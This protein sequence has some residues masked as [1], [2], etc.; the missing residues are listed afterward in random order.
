MDER[1]RTVMERSRVGFSRTAVAD[2]LMATRSPEGSPLMMHAGLTPSMSESNMSVI[3]EHTETP[4]LTPRE[5]TT[6]ALRPGLSSLNRHEIRS[7]SAVRQRLRHSPSLTPFM[8]FVREES[9]AYDPM[10]RRDSDVSEAPLYKKEVLDDQMLVLPST[11]EPVRSTTSR[12]RAFRVSAFS[13]TVSLA[14]QQFVQPTA[15]GRRDPLPTTKQFEPVLRKASNVMADGLV[16]NAPGISRTDKVFDETQDEG[17]KTV[18]LRTDISYSPAFI[19]AVVRLQAWWRG[20]LTRT[21]VTASLITRRLRYGGPLSL[22]SPA[23]NKAESLLCPSSRRRRKTQLEAKDDSIRSSRLS[24]WSPELLEQL[25]AFLRILDSRP[26]SGTTI[27][28]FN[29]CRSN[30]CRAGN[31]NHVLK[32]ENNRYKPA[33]CSICLVRAENDGLPNCYSALV[34]DTYVPL[35]AKAPPFSFSIEKRAI[36]QLRASQEERLHLA[37]RSYWD[38]EKSRT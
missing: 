21:L 31:G 9:T 36:R 33:T 2:A 37:H 28:E 38:E 32:R 27:T 15:S 20:Q 30:R 29:T 24:P 8:T 22:E 14:S 16:I 6:Q 26:L 7:L 34:E 18:T 23:V 12:I 19:A 10:I 11:A 3:S 13:P 17:L 25:T 1:R 4:D 5:D 35:V